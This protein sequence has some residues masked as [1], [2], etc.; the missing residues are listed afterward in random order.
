VKQGESSTR[1]RARAGDSRSRNDSSC[2]TRWLAVNRRVAGSSPAVGAR[3][4]RSSP[5][6]ARG[7]R[8]G[9]SPYRKYG[10]YP[11]WA[12]LGLDEDR[13]PLDASPS[14]LRRGAKGS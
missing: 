13:H 10:S 4:R 7:R 12:S 3:G 11:S 14:M 9:A 5:I 2:A 6:P 8:R 1:S